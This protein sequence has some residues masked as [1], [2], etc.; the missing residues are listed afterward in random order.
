MNEND[1]LILKAYMKAHAESPSGGSVGADANPQQSMVREITYP[2]F[3]YV[4][5]LIADFKDVPAGQ[6]SIIVPVP[7]VMDLPGTATTGVYDDDSLVLEYNTIP[8]TAEIGKC[9]VWNRVFARNALWG[10]LAS[11]MKE[12]TRVMEKKL[13]DLILD[14]FD[15]SVGANTFDA[16]NSGTLTYEDIV[17]GCAR[18]WGADLTC[19]FVLVD[20]LG[21]AQLLLDEDLINS[22]TVGTTSPVTAGQLTTVLGCTIIM[23]TAVDA[24]KAYFISKRAITVAMASDLLVEEFSR[25]ETDRYG[26]V[27][28]MVY[29]L[30]PVLPAG[31]AICNYS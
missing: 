23:S 10:A 29:G 22:Q 28:T 26:I 4:T 6:D 27:L 12:G 8:V 5:R 20:E 9:L 24:N 18:I 2:G 13:F 31:I 16:A 21:Y 11:N 19:D 30:G 17:T 25:A 7:V 3:P 15:S 14:E 1:K